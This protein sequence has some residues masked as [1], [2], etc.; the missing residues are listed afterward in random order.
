MLTTHVA[1]LRAV[2]VGGRKVLKDE[3]VDAFTSFGAP[4]SWTFLASGNVGFHTPERPGLSAALTEHLGEVFGFE[5]PVMVRAAEAVRRIARM[6]PFREAD[7][8]RYVALAHDTL[9]EEVVAR[10]DASGDGTD[11]F[12]ADGRELWWNRP[13]GRYSTSVYAGPRLERVAG[14]ALTVRRHATLQRLAKKLD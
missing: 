4:D 7:G 11:A 9:D 5:V 6:D 1:F 3:L 8:V 12:Q 10:L 13:D 14:V 2:N